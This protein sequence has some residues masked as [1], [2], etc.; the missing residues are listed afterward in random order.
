[1]Y[2]P[3]RIYITSP[4]LD[5][6]IAFAIVLNGFEIL[7]LVPVL[8]LPEDET[9]SESLPVDLLYDINFPLFSKPI[10]PKL[11]LSQTNYLVDLK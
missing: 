8:S 5:A 6:L 3:S 10:V 4:S 7:L 11:P 2:S 9:N 1:M